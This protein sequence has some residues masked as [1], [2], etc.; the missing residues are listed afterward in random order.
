M[1]KIVVI[2]QTV[3]MPDD[4]PVDYIKAL[5]AGASKYVMGAIAEDSDR[6]RFITAGY[7]IHQGPIMNLETGEQL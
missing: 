1:S 4:V 7:L 3:E 6:M 5:M 2:S